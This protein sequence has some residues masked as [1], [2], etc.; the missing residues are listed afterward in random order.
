MLK[1]LAYP[2][3]ADHRERTIGSLER[4][5][6]L[7]ERKA[8]GSANA[9]RALGVSSSRKETF[10]APGPAIP[11]GWFRSNLAHRAGASP[12]GPAVQAGGFSGHRCSRRHTR[13]GEQRV[14][15]RLP[16][17]RSRVSRADQPGLSSGR[18]PAGRPKAFRRTTSVRSPCSAATT[19]FKRTSLVLTRSMLI[20]ASVSGLK[21]LSATPA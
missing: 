15:D 1:P 21:S 12:R 3:P 5:K 8:R 16:A 20:P 14:F 4:R 9:R 10:A 6:A 13:V 17:C 7:Q 19:T 18:P 2:R 11:V